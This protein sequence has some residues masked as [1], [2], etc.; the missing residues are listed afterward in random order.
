MGFHGPHMG[1]FLQLFVCYAV[2][3]KLAP[4]ACIA[5]HV[6]LMFS[7]VFFRHLVRKPPHAQTDTNTDMCCDANCDHRTPHADH[8]FLPQCITNGHGPQHLRI[9]QPANA[10]AG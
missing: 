6:Y 5:L 3:I 10:A 1:C 8:Y 9:A 2:H 4:R 7:F